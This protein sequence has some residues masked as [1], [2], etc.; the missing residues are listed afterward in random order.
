M[1]VI[2]DSSLVIRTTFTADSPKQSQEVAEFLEKADAVVI[3]TVAFCE[4]VLVLEKHYR[5]SKAYVAKMLRLTLKISNVIVDADAVLAGV[6]M[7]EC[8]GEF[9]DGVIQ[10]TGSQMAAGKAVFASL[11]G[12]A[13]RRF[14]HQGV[15]TTIPC[16]V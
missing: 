6:Q 12:N 16:S 4:A 15:A 8:G 14:L 9:E 7:L 10:Y 5:L 13:V 2:A 3:P 11:D 1:I